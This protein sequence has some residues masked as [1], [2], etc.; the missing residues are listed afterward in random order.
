MRYRLAATYAREALALGFVDEALAAV[1]VAIGIAQANNDESYHRDS[2]MDLALVRSDMG[3]HAEAMRDSEAALQLAGGDQ[4]I[5]LLLNRGYI[6][7][8]ADALQE[9]LALYRRVRGMAEQSGESERALTA[10]LNLSTLHARLGQVQDN[11]AL[12]ADAVA[13]AEGLDQ[14]YFKGYAYAARALALIDGGELTAASEQFA[15]GR[16]LLERAG[17]HAHLAHAL[18]IWAAR[19]AARDRYGE[20]YDA[21]ARSVEMDAQVRRVERERN[22]QYLNA[23]IEAGQKDLAIER[24]RRENDVVQLQI[25]KRRLGTAAWGVGLASVTVLALILLLS[26]LRLRRASQRLAEANASLDY[27]N[28]HDALTGVHSRKHFVREFDRRKVLGRGRAMLAL[29]DVDHFKQIN[30]RYGHAVGDEVL[31]QVSRRLAGTLRRHDLIARWGGEEFIILTGR[32]DDGL[33]GADIA[34]RLRASLNRTP[35]QVGDHAVAVTASIGYVD[36]L[37]DPDSVLEDELKAVDRYL[38]RAKSEGRNRTASTAL[39]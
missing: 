16:A 8:Q 7:T 12:T 38:Y 13:M 19:L 9:A 3:R 34:E 26:Y 5:D 37:L 15:K 6:L 14:D 28:S 25:E 24:L 36:I 18:G 11:L 10:M 35:V 30:D 33:L 29:L 32:L 22:A 31:R 2:L 4:R 39:T 23:M 1:Q 21:L 27:E 20:A 17:E